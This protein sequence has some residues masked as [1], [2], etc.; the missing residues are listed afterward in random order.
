MTPVVIKKFIEPEST[1]LK[2]LKKFAGQEV[3]ILIIP[4]SKNAKKTKAKR[5][6]WIGM[7]RSNNSSIDDSRETIYK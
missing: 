2:E 4:K 5:P 3:K 7:F 1:E 6:S